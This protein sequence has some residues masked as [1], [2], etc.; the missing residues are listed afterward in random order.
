[1]KRR[2]FLLGGMASLATLAVPLAA[3]AESALDSLIAELKVEGY[4]RIRARRT[5]LG[6]V[7]IRARKG[8]IRREIVMN[9]VTGEI[10]RDYR[11]DEEED[12]FD[13]FDDDDDFDGERYDDDEDDGDDDDD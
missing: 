2:G 3:R 5:W 13:F 4:T 8:K 7:Q 10:L 12:G 11:E 1:M 9:P 6:R